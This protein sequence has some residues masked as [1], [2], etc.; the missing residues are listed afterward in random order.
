LE[1]TMHLGIPRLLVLAVA[2]S[3]CQ[4]PIQGHYEINRAAPFH[5]YAT[6]AWITADPLVRPAAGVIPGE[7]VRVSPVMEQV[8]RQAVDRKLLEK[9]FEKRADPESADLIVS[10]S[11]GARDKIQVTS[12][13]AHSGY[14]YGAW[15]GG[16]Q[17]DV[18]TY[19][20]GTLAIDV[21]DVR[22]HQAVW[23]GWASKRVSTSTDQAQR[24]ATL[25]EAVDAILGQFPYRNTQQ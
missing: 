22:T 1:K 4:T 18:R 6:F 3:A 9:G 16:W 17:S 24:T 10:F 15:G 7:Q 13:P 19:T 25:N 11:V 23:H 8:L 20:E 2:L 12:Y 21:F 5:S 14:R